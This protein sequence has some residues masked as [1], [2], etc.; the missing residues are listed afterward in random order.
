MIKKGIEGIC[1]KCVCFRRDLRGEF[2]VF[3]F[4]WKVGCCLFGMIIGLFFSFFRCVGFRFRF[5]FYDGGR[6]R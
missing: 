5:I 3:F 4:I 2:G 6:I 1:E